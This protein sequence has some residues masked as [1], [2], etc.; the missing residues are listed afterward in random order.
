M[1]FGT[2]DKFDNFLA[3]TEP[4]PAPQS[5]PAK[6]P[7]EGGEEYDDAELSVVIRLSLIF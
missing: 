6:I 1:G 2:D 7:N 4:P 5:T 3:L